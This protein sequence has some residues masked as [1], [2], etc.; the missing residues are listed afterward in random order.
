MNSDG[1]ITLPADIQPS[2]IGTPVGIVYDFDGS[3]TDALL[4]QGAGDSGQCFFNAV[5]GGDD[6]FGAFATYQHALIVINGQCVQQSSQLNDVEYRLV[7]MIGNVVG[8]G[9]SQLNPNVITGS[10]HPTSD[11]YAGF[12]VMHF[13]DPMSCVPITLCYPNRAPTLVG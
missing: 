8:L 3:V 5:F 11:D 4:G 2:A 6:N 12:P 1:S 10:P 9:W 13:S 7:R